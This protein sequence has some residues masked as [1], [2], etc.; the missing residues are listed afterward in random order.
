MRVALTLEYGA[1]LESENLRGQTW[2]ALRVSGSMEKPRHREAGGEYKITKPGESRAGAAPACDIQLSVPSPPRAERDQG[3]E[4]LGV[5]FGCL[6]LLVFWCVDK[7]EQRPQPGG[8][9]NHLTSLHPATS[10]R[11]GSVFTLG[12][13]RS[14][15]NSEDSKDAGPR[16]CTAGRGH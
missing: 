3:G 4:A 6:L 8:A 15:R 7:E 5:R 13:S 16:G 2:E 14:A 12:R 11:A 9:C 1:F 10:P